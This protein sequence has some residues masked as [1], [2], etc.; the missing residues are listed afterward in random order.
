MTEDSDLKAQ[1]RALLHTRSDVTADE[2]IARVGF[3]SSS[4]RQPG[5]ERASARRSKARAIRRWHFGLSGR[6][7]VVWAIGV[8]VLIAAVALGA[9][10]LSTSN[11]GPKT[12]TS[13][14]ASSIPLPTTETTPPPPPTTQTSP[15]STTSTIVSA[16]RST[17]VD[18][19][20][21]W[22]AAGSLNSH[23]RSLGHLSGGSCLVGS[24]SDA[25]I[26]DTSNEYAWRCSTDQGIYDPCF[27][28]RGEKD[29]SELACAATPYLRLDVYLLD[30]STPLA[31]SSTG[32][33]PNGVWPLV[34]L[35][36]NG[37]QC[38]VIQGTAS[39][40]FNFHYGCAHGTA[41]QPTTAHEP[42][43]VSYLPNGAN[44]PVSVAVTTVWE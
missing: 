36:S 7:A 11:N 35:L 19:F 18:S 22:I 9:N 4:N 24:K 30:L 31:S 37:D 6:A 29:V 17:T 10:V 34:L 39:P 20:N 23:Y 32:F 25:S 1:F 28:P 42:W 43:T 13:K 44:T 8:S 5:N 26:A 38:T 40:P 3:A 27:A 14:V 41:S 21:P 33:T 12:P 15:R 16:S 2:V